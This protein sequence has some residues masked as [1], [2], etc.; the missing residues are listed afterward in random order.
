VS[1]N[2]HPQPATFSEAAVAIVGAGPKGIGVLERICASV[3]ELLGDRSLVVHLVDPYPPGAGR[4]WRHDQSPLLL[5]NSKARDVTMFTDDTVVCEGPAQP[6]PTLAEWTEQVREGT[7]AAELHPGLCAELRAANPASFHTRRLHSAYL[8]W[9]Y[10]HVLDSRPE[11]VDIRRH[12]V[13]AVDLTEESNG[14]QLL[15]LHGEPEPL[16]VDA[17]VL[18]VGHLDA[19]PDETGREHAD[20]AWRHGGRYFPPAYTA[21]VDLS[22][23]EPGETVL[24]RGF[25]LAFIDLV[26]LL[27]EGRDGR[28]DSGPDGTLTYRPSGT[29]P[30]LHV[31]SRRGVPYRPKPAYE[32][33]GPPA[34]LPRFFGPAEIDRL[35]ARP[36]PIR[37]RADVWPLIAKEICWA[38]YTELFTGHPDRVTMPFEEFHDRYA[39]LDWAGDALAALVTEA[40]P[41]VADRLD[42]AR[43]DRPLAGL[44]STDPDD[45]GRLVREHI[46]AV[47]TRCRDSAFSADLGV[48]LAM[49][50]VFRQMPGV[51]A[52]GKV[53][54]ASQLLDVDGWW[55][56][57]FS[58]MASGPPTPRLHELLALERAGIVSFIGPEMWVDADE[59]Q[60]RFLAGSRC[61]PGTVAGSTLVEAR[62][63]TSQ[64]ARSANPLVRALYR[65]GQLGEEV[66][67]DGETSRFTGRIH[68][69]GID[70]RLI[71]ADGN[72][73]PRRFALG[74]QTSLR[75]AG[76]F[77][78]PRTNAIGFRENDL[79]ARQ[80]L[81][82]VRRKAHHDPQDLRSR[83]DQR[84]G[85]QSE[86]PP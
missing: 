36:G 85:R 80:I 52:T 65:R 67:S 22:V 59:R 8:R 46:K 56:G 16:R 15:W 51:V 14:K 61:A 81:Q 26:T 5:M 13:Q 43:L 24:V 25:G 60:G 78:R 19:E 54:P 79:V 83:A 33:L 69:T 28:Y 6:G 44:R 35:A 58:Y 47:L 48:T 37:F 12:A 49:L 18:S 74:P 77:S 71:D 1:D 29:E 76:A 82:L 70:G 42:L 75:I 4:V 10:R 63:P 66:L 68:T 62:L 21:D 34:V 45:L 23:I 3:P 7:L 57:F 30:R 20:F 55:F 9:Y 39:E 27:T 41:T 84:S 50:S 32:L 53:E 17:V 38:Y 72:V 2:R 73:H 11:S 86:G 31:G 64:V 40:V